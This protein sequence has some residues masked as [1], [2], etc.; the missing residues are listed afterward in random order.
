VRRRIFFFA[1]RTNLFA[2]CNNTFSKWWEGLRMTC[3]RVLSTTPLWVWGSETVGTA[4]KGN[5]Q[6][7][8]YK[9][10]LQVLQVA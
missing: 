4:G 3:R 2:S 7:K 6:T 5:L 1:L 8:A 10:E 9:Q